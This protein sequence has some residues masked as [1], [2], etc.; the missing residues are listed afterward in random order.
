MRFRT[1]TGTSLRLLPNASD[2]LS[3]FWY[4]EL[5]DFEELAFTL[6]L[7]G[8]GDLFVDVGANQG[9]WSLAA[10]GRGARV[11]S[12]EPAPLTCER[13][14]ANI[15]DNPI[16]VRQRM[17]VFPCGLSDEV[18]RVTFTTNLDSGN[19]RVRKQSDAEFGSA[20]V[21]FD[22]ADN[23]LRGEN[24]VVLKIDVEGEELG[25]LKG[26]GDVLSAPSLAAVVMETFR[27]QDFAD[28]D[29]VESEAIL[30]EHDFIPVGYNPWSRDIAPLVKPGDGAQNTIYVRSQD[31]VLVRLRKAPPLRAF[32]KA[33]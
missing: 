5:P 11:F 4:L 28:P 17:R 29:L 15:A 2:S 32:G 8:P 31:A 12:F 7:L 9:G 33:I 20:T 18:G 27:P 26:A 19:H 13:L 22:R 30:R 23:L 24:P 1:L 10:A 14:R 25:V 16:E 21:D 3:G 6:H